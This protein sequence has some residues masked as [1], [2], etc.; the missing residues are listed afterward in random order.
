MTSTDLCA[1]LQHELPLLFECS[2]RTRG[3]VRIRTP[4][5]LPD[6]DVVDLFASHHD[7]EYRV[8]DYGLAVS[9]LRSQSPS[10]KLTPPLRSLI[11]D[12]L[13]SLDVRLNR[14]QLEASCVN[15]RDLPTAVHLV[16]QA[17]VRVADV[18]HAMQGRVIRSIADDVDDWLRQKEFQVQRRTKHRGMNEL[19]QV[20]FEIKAGARTSLAFLLS[21]GSR[22]GARDVRHR[23]YT[24]FSDLR[25]NPA[26]PPHDALISLIDDTADVWTEEDFAL[27]NQVSRLA[28]WSR[29]DEVERVLATASDRLD[30]PSPLPNLF[31]P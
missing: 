2:P 7:D 26:G 9:W 19:W 10:G 30:S 24:G 5:V 3:D 22:A 18:R 8:S 25:L 28:M 17:V 6:R 27:L 11:D 15:A 13:Q 20:D 31:R 1:T 12:L 16:G 4:F 21:S 23:V 29:P 14:G